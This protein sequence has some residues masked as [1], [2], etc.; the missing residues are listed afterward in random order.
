M[1]F[2]PKN[3]ANPRGAPPKIRRFEGALIRALGRRFGTLDDGLV[4]M[5]EALIDIICDADHT[6]RV[7]AIRDLRDTI[8]GKPKQQIDIDSR[9]TADDLIERVAKQQAIN[10]SDQL[11]SGGTTIN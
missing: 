5:A 11:G 10:A 4:K 6:Q 2:G 1:P 9:P 7:Q 3:I 8:D